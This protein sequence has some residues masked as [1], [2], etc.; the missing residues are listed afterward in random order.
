MGGLGAAMPRA[1]AVGRGFPHAMGR[2]L[3]GLIG[4][5][6]PKWMERN[7]ARSMLHSGPIDSI[8]PGRTDRHHVHVGSGSYV[9][10]ADA[11]SHI[12][13]NNTKAG[14]AILGHMFGKA[15]PYGA[16]LPSIKHGSTMP[17]PGKVGAA[18][19]ATH[20]PKFT[21]TG[22]G[23][24]D[25][26]G[27]PVPVEVAGGEYTIPREIV[28]NIGGGDIKRGHRILDNWV[29]SLRKKHIATLRGLPPPAKS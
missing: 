25:S 28:E 4:A 5:P 26:T 15:G 27:E 12:G 13:Q 22:G 9:L 11:V 18:I 14:Q 6:N 3:G 7:E 8:V 10:P 16:G 20:L 24:N 17:K 19:P 23:K 29:L 1:P 2:D 21:S